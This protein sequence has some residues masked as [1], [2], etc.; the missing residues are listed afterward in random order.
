MTDNNTS[1]KY[2]AFIS[3]SH[4]DNKWGDWLHRALETY[5]VPKKLIGT[6]GRDGA[7]PKRVFPIFRDRDELPTSSDLGSNIN[8]ALAQSRYLIVICSPN[9]AKSQWV[10]EEIKTFK[11]LGREN[12]ILCLIVGGEPNASDKDDPNLNECFPEAVRFR[13]DSNAQITSERTEPIAADVREGMDKKENAKLKLLAGILGVD[14]DALRQ[15]DKERARKIFRIRLAIVMALLVSCSVGGW[16]WWDWARIKTF[17]YASYGERYGVPFGI[18]EIDSETYSHR[19][20][21]YRFESQHHRVITVSYINSASTLRDDDEKHNASQW[22]ISYRDD[23]HVESITYLDHN[24][25]LK[26]I[27][28]FDFDDGGRQAVVSFKQAIGKVAMQSAK[29]SLLGSIKSSIENK[30]EISQHR[31]E[32]DNQGYVVR[33]YYESVYGNRIADGVGSYGKA[34]EYTALGQVKVERNIGIDGA[35]LLLKD[36]V[37]EI[38]WE[39]DIRGNVIKEASFGIDR[40]PM[41]DQYKNAGSASKY[42]TWDNEI[43]TAYFG[44]DGEPILMNKGYARAKLKYDARG[45]EIQ[46]AH[47]G[48]DGEPVLHQDGYASYT[49]KYDARGNVIEYAYFGIDGEPV[50]SQDGYAR[51]TSKYDARG[52]EIEMASFGINGKPV[53]DKYGS[54][55]DILKYD[56]R[57]N[58]IEYAFLI[59]HWITIC[60]KGALL[61]HVTPRIVFPGLTGIAVLM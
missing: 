10:N 58:L 48:I 47:F 60:A 13:V 53:L 7:I 32:F 2:Y 11:S 40:V 38:R 22:Q 6:L 36:G 37:F 21:S 29:G 8:D 26:M 31:L 20:F 15:R 57:G 14:F 45:N 24:S 50:L 61:N 44:T 28:K 33:H 12:K 59:Q 16:Y 5:R 51:F 30:T 42:D 46:T 18:N 3:Y 56:A 55:R 34:Y 1:Y 4:Q 52:N 49:S 27:E 43:E 9:S 19:Q 25:Q 39:H 17:H 35:Y 23:G 41:L 54:A